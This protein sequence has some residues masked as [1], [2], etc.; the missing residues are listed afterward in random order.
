M[1]KMN[2]GFSVIARCSKCIANE[3]N[4]N[5]KSLDFELDFDIETAQKFLM[6]FGP[7]VV[8]LNNDILIK[9]LRKPN[10]N[11]FIIILVADEEAYFI[12]NY[13][14]FLRDIHEGY[15]KITALNKISTIK[16]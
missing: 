3:D 14:Q 8:E 7:D 6:K 13:E 10:S 4:I 16:R 9:F 2:L 15:M 5:E 11:D 1:M 12:R